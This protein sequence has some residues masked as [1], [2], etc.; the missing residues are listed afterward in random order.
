M[1]PV[2]TWTR[3][4][5]ALNFLQLLVVLLAGVSWEKW[6]SAYS[7]FHLSVHVSPVVGGLLAYFV[8]TFI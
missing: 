5:L 6:F 1:P 2:P 7:V 3:R 4:V 8:A